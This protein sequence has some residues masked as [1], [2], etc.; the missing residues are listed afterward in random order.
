VRF[1]GVEK[2]KD[3][4]QQKIVIRKR[5]NHPEVIYSRCAQSIYTIQTSKEA[6]TER[7]ERAGYEEQRV[8]AVAVLNVPQVHLL[9]NH[10]HLAVERIRCT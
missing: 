3:K 7:T 1:G 4:R 2:A 8:R 5:S 6:V 10:T 9:F